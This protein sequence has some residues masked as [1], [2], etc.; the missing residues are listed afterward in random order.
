MS[1]T[2]TKT[3][4]LLAGF[5]FAGMIVFDGC[6]K[7]T[8]PDKKET[9]PAAAES[10]K[11]AAMAAAASEMIEQP[12]CPVMGGPVDKDVSIVYQGKKVYFCCTSCKAEFEKDPAKYIS[13]LPQFKK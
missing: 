6:R 4:V 3:I 5:L 11:S 7:S 13:K 12:I 1:S 10:N 2:N 8:P 9:V